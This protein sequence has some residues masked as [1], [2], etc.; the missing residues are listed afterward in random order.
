MAMMGIVS[1][2]DATFNFDK[3]GTALPQGSPL[4]RRFAADEYEFYFQ[5]SYRVRSN[6]TVTY[7]LR[8]SMF[9]PPWETNGTEVTPKGFPIGGG[10]P[11][12]L[13]QWF[14]QRASLPFRWSPRV[15]RTLNN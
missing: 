8:Y 13:A 7:G 12:S 10:S 5:D 4:R 11:I 9:S 15:V 1:E 14:Q 3:T 2:V 6:L